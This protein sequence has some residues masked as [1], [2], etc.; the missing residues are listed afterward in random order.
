MK[1]CYDQ[2]YNGIGVV[3]ATKWRHYLFYLQPYFLVLGT[4]LSQSFTGAVSSNSRLDV[5]QSWELKTV[6]ASRIAT[7]NLVNYDDATIYSGTSIQRRA[8]GLAESVGY[9]EVSLHRGSFSYNFTITEAHN[10]KN[11]D[12]S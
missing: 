11:P 2:G 5:R 6:S 7:E 9:N 1:I 8:K 4:V 3:I 12:I 10:D